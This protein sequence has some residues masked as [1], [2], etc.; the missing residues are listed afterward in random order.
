MGKDHQGVIISVSTKA[1]IAKA[2]TM[3]TFDQLTSAYLAAT[4]QDRICQTFN[5]RDKDRR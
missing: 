2:H 5:L 4:T 3:G 1:A